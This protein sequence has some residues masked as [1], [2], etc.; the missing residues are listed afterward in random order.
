MT[1]YVPGTLETD[2][3]K[4]IMS[5]QALAASADVATA[6]QYLN[7]TAGK[8]LTT[9]QFWSAAGTV[10][11]TDASTVTMDFSTFI[12]AK[13]TGTASVGA[14]RTLGAA[15]NV[16]VGQFGVIEWFPVTSATT[17]VIPTGSSYVAAGG[18]STLSLSNTNGARDAITYRVLNDNKVLL[19]VQKA[20][21]T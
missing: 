21:A 19:S 18:I 20:L 5:L 8:V 15:S 13:L 2:L 6:A 4:V 7:N 16:K 3:K 12:N 11:L 17:L 10:T 1:V 14:S 9:D